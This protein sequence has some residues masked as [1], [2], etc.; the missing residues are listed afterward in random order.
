MDDPRSEQATATEAGGWIERFDAFAAMPKDLRA[1]LQTNSQ[2]MRVRAGSS[3]FGPGSTANSF[4]L[5]LSGT[6]RVQK[7]SSNGRE[8]V[9][10]RI[11]AGESCIMTTACLLAEEDYLAEGITETEV[12]AVAVSRRAF[13]EL[14]ANCDIFR[15]FVFNAYSM[16]ITELFMIINEIA[17]SRIDIRLAQR[18]LRLADDNGQL[19][20]THQALAVELGTAREVITRQLREFQRRGWIKL[21]RGSIALCDH[22]ALLKTSQSA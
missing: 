8:I 16:R 2:V 6:V 17:F 22:K 13:D 5:M 15:R 7:T 3:I 1:Y 21:T 10:Y 11:S 12:E 9:L 4:L 20:I 14:I 18:L 19:S